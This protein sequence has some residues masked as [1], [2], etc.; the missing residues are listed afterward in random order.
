MCNTHF[1]GTAVGTAVGMTGLVSVALRHKDYRRKI[2]A[3]LQESGF[4]YIIGAARNNLLRDV[5]LV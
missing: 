5:D 3:E 1:T 2:K 4:V